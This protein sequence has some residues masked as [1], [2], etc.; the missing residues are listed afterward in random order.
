MTRGPQARPRRSAVERERSR[1]TGTA[2]R[3]RC[4]AAIARRSASRQTRHQSRD[5]ALIES[6]PAPAHGGSRVPIPSEPRAGGLPGRSRHSGEV[7]QLVEHAAE[8]RGVGGSIPSLATTKPAAEPVKTRTR[9]APDGRRPRPFR[10]PCPG[11]R[12]RR[13][14]RSR[15]RVGRACEQRFDLGGPVP[16]VASEGAN[17][18]ELPRLRPARHGLRVDPKPRRN[19]SGRQEL[20]HVLPVPYHRSPR[21]TPR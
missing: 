3:G 13:P 20:L 18:G 12:L 1:S 7:A 2:R 16:P 21:S 8:N 14:E 5:P 10:S 15:L 17:R 19:L 6:P 4:L 9:P 11:R